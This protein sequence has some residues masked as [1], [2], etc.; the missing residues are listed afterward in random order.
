MDFS[1]KLVYFRYTSRAI[2][3]D[4]FCLAFKPAGSA[5]DDDLVA[6]GD[7]VVDAGGLIVGDVDGRAVFVIDGDDGETDVDGEDEDGGGVLGAVGDEVAGEV[8]SA[9]DPILIDGPGC[10]PLSLQPDRPMTKSKALVATTIRRCFAQPGITADPSSR[11]CCHWPDGGSI[12]VGDAWHAPPRRLPCAR[13]G[14]TTPRIVGD[15]PGSCLAHNADERGARQD[16]PAHPRVNRSQMGHR[17]LLRPRM[18][19][20]R[21]IRYLHRMTDLTAEEG[22]AMAL[23][24]RSSARVVVRLDRMDLPAGRFAPLRYGFVGPGPTHPQVSDGRRESIPRHQLD[25]PRAADAEDL[26][27]LGEPDNRR[28]THRATVPTPCTGSSLQ[29][30][31][32]TVQHCDRWTSS[33]REPRGVPGE[34]VRAHIDLL[35]AAGLSRAAIARQAGIATSTLGRIVAGVPVRDIDPPAVIR[36]STAARILA[37]APTLAAAGGGVLI[38]SKEA[39]ELVITLEGRGW[40]LPTIAAAINRSTQS[41][42]RSLLR[43]NVLAGTVTALLALT[44]GAR[45]LPYPRRGISK[46]RH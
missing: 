37:V 40:T 28:L 2:S 14:V 32:D 21:R 46:S 38:P 20:L 33:D 31:T 22:S 15:S 13:P 1:I 36:T 44:V 11:P 39:R 5:T 23:Q 25:C 27:D 16:E 45:P 24:V 30:N 35:R 17:E 12:R 29:S 6:G 9:I 41:L 4:A 42:R 26:Y 8:S 3:A 7:D 18:S 34:Q 19:T 43:P 10:A